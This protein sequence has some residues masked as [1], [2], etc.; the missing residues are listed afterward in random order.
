M[1]SLAYMPRLAAVVRT[2]LLLALFAV[3][4]LSATGARADTLPSEPDAFIKAVADR[5]IDEILT[6]DISTEERIAKF[7]SLLE[8]AFDLEAV[9]RFVVG[10]A[11]RS[12]SE[13]EKT[14][15]IELFKQF[16]VFNWGSRFDEY[17]GQRL[18]VS[19]VLPDSDKGYFIETR[20]GSRDGNPFVVTWRVRKRDVGL[21]IV[22]ISVEG[23]WMSQTWRSE[24]ASVLKDTGSLSGLNEVLEDR[25][26]DLKAK[27]EL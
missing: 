1:T 18:E 21:R 10:R 24:Y 12:A 20:I 11:W 2:V 15:F 6:P 26:A 7:E 23:I 8:D 4:A 9:G 22:D 25:V 14:R 13:A 16:N 19:N 27:S 5:A 17:G 3:P